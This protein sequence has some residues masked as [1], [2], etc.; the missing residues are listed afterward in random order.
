M[1]NEIDFGDI[2]INHL[3]SLIE[4]L[5]D[6]INKL[7]YIYEETINYARF[8]F[9]RLTP[10]EQELITN[11]SKLTNAENEWK[12]LKDEKNKVTAAINK[13]PSLEKSDFK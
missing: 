3:I 5:P 8:L 6:D 10:E 1:I 4:V 9:N 2:K 13:I 11:I 7:T 12:R